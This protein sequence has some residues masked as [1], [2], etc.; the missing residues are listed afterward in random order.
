MNPYPYP[1]HFDN[2][3]MRNGRRCIVLTRPFAAKTSL[4]MV[5]APAGFVSDGGSIPRFAWS[6]IGHPLDEYLE[7]TVIHDFMY[8]PLNTTFDRAE[9]DFVFKE[10][11]WNHDISRPKLIAMYA[12]VR[13]FGWR[14]FKGRPA[15][16][17]ENTW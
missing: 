9:A 15:I 7:D 1:I 13:M 12:A 17:V 6:I 16:T 5:T 11:M 14:G 2:A 4:G 3:G 10:L 8:S